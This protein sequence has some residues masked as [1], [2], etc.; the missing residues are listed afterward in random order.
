[1]LI[2][3]DFFPGAGINNKS[4]ISSNTCI[5]CI[6]TGSSLF[7]TL[8]KISKEI[9]REL[10]SLNYEAGAG[11][12]WRLRNPANDTVCKG[13]SSFI[14]IIYVV[15]TRS[16]KTRQSWHLTT[17]PPSRHLNVLTVA[18][19]GTV[20]GEVTIIFVSLT[21]LTHLVAWLT[22][23]SWDLRKF[24]NSDSTVSLKG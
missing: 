14:Y 11:P 7:Y 17:K 18:Y 8:E 6:V 22:R 1:M 12:K 20:S 19:K 13:Q 23:G 2:F 21:K 9:L 4:I 16:T 24:E 3:V 10:W 15:C 5:C